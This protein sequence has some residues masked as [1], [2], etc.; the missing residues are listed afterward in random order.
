MARV[1]SMK[2]GKKD[3]RETRRC[4]EVGAHE[5]ID[6]KDGVR[7]RDVWRKPNLERRHGARVEEEKRN[8]NIPGLHASVAGIEMRD[9][10]RSHVVPRGFLE[11]EGWRARAAAGRGGW[12][13]I[14]EAA[15]G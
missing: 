3:K 4:L 5:A 7:V 15:R 1:R 12:R 11:R 2:Q 10:T 6:D 14:G 13:S 9:A 8:D